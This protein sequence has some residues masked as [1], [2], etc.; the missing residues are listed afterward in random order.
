MHLS[1]NFA[2]L[3]WPGRDSQRARRSLTVAFTLI[4]LLV[5]I[6]IIA[7]LAAMLLPALAKAKAAASQTF[8]K[9]SLK[10]LGLGM[11]MYCDSNGGVYAGCASRGDYGAQLPDWIYWRNPTVIG[12]VT[13]T[14]AQSPLIQE[15]STKATTNIFRCP[16]DKDDSTR[17]ANGDPIYYYSYAFTSFN[18]TGDNQN[19][20]LTTIMEGITYKF[21]QSSVRG[22]SKKIM[23]AEGE[24]SFKANEAPPP[25]SNNFGAIL[26]S[27]RWQA[28]SG[29]APHNYL[30]IRH[31]GNGDVTF[32]DGHVT[33]VSWKF[34]TNILNVQPGL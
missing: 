19:L 14:L 4:E 2:G 10:Q 12:G 23:T 6:A 25:G 5:V 8:C 34:C 3:G 9:N 13:Y 28:F 20:G 11:L 30:T 15:L 1:A 29:G 33:A 7:I 27:G 24:V 32:A 21:K 26:E 18:L 22:P 16:L 31:G 17:I